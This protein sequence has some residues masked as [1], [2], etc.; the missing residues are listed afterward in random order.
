MV[1]RRKR[2]CAVSGIE[3]HDPSIQVG[4]EP[5]VSEVSLLDGTLPPLAFVPLII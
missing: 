3:S 2:R 1:K 4:A 5:E